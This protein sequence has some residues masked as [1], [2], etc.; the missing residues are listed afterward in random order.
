MVNK[1]EKRGINMSNTE[2]TIQKAGEVILT[3]YKGKE[4]KDFP[5]YMMWGKPGIGKSDLVLEIVKT[6]A[7]ERKL[8]YTVKD[9][10]LA[11]YDPIDIKGLP[12][13]DKDG[14][15]RF[16]KP[17][18]VDFDNNKDYIHVLFLDE[19][20]ATPPATQVACYQLILNRRIGEYKLPD[21]VFI[22][23]A[24]NGREHGSVSYKMPRA[25]SNRMYHLDTT[26][27]FDSWRAWAIKNGIDPRITA[28]LREQPNELYSDL[29]HCGNAY[30]TPR[31]WASLSKTIEGTNMTKENKELMYL[32]CQS[33]I[34]ETAIDFVEFCLQQYKIP[35]FADIVSRNYKG[36]DV[37]EPGLMYNLES[38]LI[39]EIA[40]DNEKSNTITNVKAIAEFMTWL[41]KQNV[42]EY[43]AILFKDIR[44]LKKV[45]QDVY[46]Y[47][48]LV[49]TSRK[50]LVAKMKEWMSF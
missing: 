19:L 30:C 26:T 16:T 5:T 50:E 8:K 34:G 37:N 47:R 7:D 35:T 48:E 2:I 36:V 39:Y 29:K 10:R 6:I 38:N 49:K 46:Y 3:A 23:A 4:I 20:S 43:A 24:G 14:V 41:D 42:P 32:L 21:N 28:F 22:I 18:I 33:A 9:C 13:I 11:S 17:D 45:P 27:D 25:L 44:S 31:S 40:K 12:F 1:I 15:S